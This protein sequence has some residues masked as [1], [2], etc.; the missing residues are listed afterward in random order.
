MVRTN[1]EILTGGKKYADKAKK[2]HRVEEVVFDRDSRV[3]YLTGFHKRKLQRQ[4]KAQEYHAEQARLERIKERKEIREERKQDLERQMKQFNETQKRIANLNDS[5]DD[6]DDNDAQNSDESEDEEWLGFQ[7]D[8]KSSD[9]DE[10]LDLKPKGILHRKEVYIR[11][12]D[13]VGGDAIIEEETTVEVELLESPAVKEMQEIQRLARANNV[14][15]SKLE[16]VLDNSIERAKNYAVVCGVAKPKP[17]SKKKF[18]YLTKAERRENN[19]K[20]KAK[21][22]R[23]RDRA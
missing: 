6:D 23:S 18:R 9:S 15:L 12:E 5:S 1:R 20:I 22:Q 19:R 16:Q 7:D 14:D 10:N 4:K 13:A 2:A 8:D 11:D 3:E 21:K 17:K